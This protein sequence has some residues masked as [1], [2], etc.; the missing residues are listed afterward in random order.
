VI[1]EQYSA[2]PSGDLPSFAKSAAANHHCGTAAARCTR[3]TRDT[4]PQVGPPFSSSQALLPA[5]RP[6]FDRFLIRSEDQLSCGC[7][8]RYPGTLVRA[9]SGLCRK[10]KADGI[11]ARKE[12][13]M[14]TQP[15]PA[16]PTFQFPPTPERLLNSREVAEWLGV[17]LDWVQAHATR[18]NPRIPAVLLGTGRHD[19]R[20]C[21]FDGQALR[22]S[23]STT[24]ETHC[25]CGSERKSV[26][27]A[28]SRCD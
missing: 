22:S 2:K 1:V 10:P 20:R 23:S 8:N 13:Y 6:A 19:G 5:S 21:G 16:P 14:S 9:P 15:G 24:W 25:H 12:T 17:S 4:I 28:Q 7:R 11:S 27:P 18:S 3:F 26:S